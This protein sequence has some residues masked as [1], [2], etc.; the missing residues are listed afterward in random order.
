MEPR[1]KLP[2]SIKKAVEDLDKT[3]DFA[4]YIEKSWRLFI[5]GNKEKFIEGFMDLEV[6][7][8]DM[9]GTKCATAK[10]RFPVQPQHCDVFGC[11]GTG[12]ATTLGDMVTIHL[13][14]SMIKRHDIQFVS[15]NIATHCVHLEPPGD[16]IEIFVETHDHNKDRGYARAEFR[17]ASDGL[18]LYLVT[19]TMKPL[20]VPSRY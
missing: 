15:L 9:T 17:R 8:A 4:Q 16:D 20:T 6:V 18:L 11:M 2:P 7:E 12:F 14:A 1:K 5:H 10:L 13:T 3:T 19:Q